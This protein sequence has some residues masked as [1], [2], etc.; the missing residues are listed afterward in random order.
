M[1]KD[2]NDLKNNTGS[3]IVE[4]S[5]FVSEASK[6]AAE[7]NEL[8]K[9]KQHVARTYGIF[10]VELFL[11][12]LVAYFMSTQPQLLGQITSVMYA[13]MGIPL[14]LVIFGVFALLNRAQ[15]SESVGLSVLL[16][17]A[18]IAV[19]GIPL[20]II[21]YVYNSLVVYEALAATSIIY[22]TTAVYG[23]V[24]KKNY[25]TWG[26]PL[27]GA[28][29]AVIVMMIISNFVHNSW[30]TMG[31]LLANILIF[32][33]YIIYDNQMIKV[34]FLAKLRDGVS[35]SSKS[36]WLLA[37]SSSTNIYLDFIN[38]FMSILRLLGNR[39]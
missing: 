9:L 24:T 19:I 39:D 23:L 2:L 35:D 27:F 3:S 30:L 14:I 26:G 7:D 25:T 33:L 37:L 21:P 29:I 22:I 4:K 17:L 28:L 15:R 38:L 5:H 6:I 12:G 10:I 13:G 11:T 31:I 32:T 8:S 1:P 18:V 36:W 16:T 20:G 34:Q